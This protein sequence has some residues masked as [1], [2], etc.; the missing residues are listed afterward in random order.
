M[1]QL[2]YAG[3]QNKRSSQKRPLS[4]QGL[5]VCLFFYGKIIK[6]KGNRRH[7]PFCY[8]CALIDFDEELN[9]A[10]YKAKVQIEHLSEQNI[11]YES[12]DEMVKKEDEL[13]DGIVL[14]VI[15]SMKSIP[16]KLGKKTN[17]VAELE[18]SVKKE[19]PR[20]LTEGAEP[21]L[22]ASKA[23]LAQKKHQDVVSNNKA[24]A[25]SKKSEVSIDIDA[26][27]AKEDETVKE[28]KEVV[29]ASFSEESP[30]S[31]N[32]FGDDDDDDNLF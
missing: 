13:T 1:S 11:S 23:N 3:S 24:Q 10:I 20:W 5:F 18:E 15:R 31:V 16:D 26:F 6:D 27:L 12:K 7:K 28:E 25:D 9:K 2:S 22:A 30:D 21:N 19:I 29:G 17:A 32:I 14:D 8:R 4:N